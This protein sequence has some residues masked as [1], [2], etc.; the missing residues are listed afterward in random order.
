MQNIRQT[1]IDALNLDT[2][3]EEMQNDAV[4]EM[5][6]HIFQLLVVHAMTVLNEKDRETLANFLDADT[7]IGTVFSFLEEK[8]PDIQTIAEESIQ[9]YAMA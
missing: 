6:E 1:I 7:D 2:L 3:P 5:G 8:V 9:L 4:K